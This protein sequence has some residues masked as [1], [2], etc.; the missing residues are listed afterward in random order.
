MTTLQKAHSQIVRDPVVC[1]LTVAFQTTPMFILCLVSCS[2]PKVLNLY[3][4]LNCKVSENNDGLFYKGRTKW[5]DEPIRS[6]VGSLDNY[7]HRPGGGDKDI[8]EIKYHLH[9]PNSISSMV[10]YSCLTMILQNRVFRQK[11][12]TGQGETTLEFRETTTMMLV[13]FSVCLI[14]L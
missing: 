10:S 7:Y 11:S 1:Q 9:A 3:S 14:E 12:S 4:Q 6:K 2:K 5:S 8:R 13:T